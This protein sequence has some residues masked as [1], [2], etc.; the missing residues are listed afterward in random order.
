MVTGLGPALAL[1]HCLGDRGGSIAEIGV[2]PTDEASVETVRVVDAEPGVSDEPDKGV[3]GVP[4]PLGEM[5]SFIR[6]D[7]GGTSGGVLSDLV[8]LFEGRRERYCGR[9]DDVVGMTSGA[10]DLG[11]RGRRLGEVEFVLFNFILDE[12]SCGSAPLISSKRSNSAFSSNAGPEIH[13]IILSPKAFWRQ[14]LPPGAL[15][16][17]SCSAGRPGIVAGIVLERPIE[18]AINM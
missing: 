18:N 12:L 10:R 16:D 6:A 15:M 14:L 1:I 5:R 11:E 2:V 9:E 3:Y 17:R 8:R 13:D 7:L 4:R